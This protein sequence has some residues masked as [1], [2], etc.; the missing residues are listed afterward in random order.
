MG[1]Y[2]ELDTARRS[3]A[4]RLIGVWVL[5]ANALGAA[6]AGETFARA[7]E[8]ARRQLWPEARLAFAKGS[9]AYPRDKRFPIELAGV[10]WKLEDYGAAKRQLRRALSIDADDAFANE[11][12]ATIFLLEDNLEAS[13]RYW[14]RAGGPRLAE[15]QTQSNLRLQGALLERTFPFSAGTT[16][17]RRDYIAARA[18]L[19][20]LGIFPRYRIDLVP[21]EDADYA[22]RLRASEK[23]GFGA[24]TQDRLLNLFRGVFF[25]TLYPEYSNWRGRAINIDSLL[26]WDAQKQRVLFSVAGPMQGDPGR[27]GRVYVD[28]RRENW[29]LARTFR[30][31]AVP[32]EG[33]EFRYAA[34]GAE[35]RGLEPG[36]WSWRAAAE[37][38]W[39]DVPNRARYGIANQAVFTGG[40]AAAVQFGAGY[41][42]WRVPERRLTVTGESTAELGRVIGRELRPF[43]QLRTSVEANWLPRARGDDYAVNTRFYAGKVAGDAPL[44]RLFQLGIERDNDL[45]LRGHAGTAGGRKGNAP[46]GTGIVLANWEFDKI[47]YRNG[48]WS[49]SAGP[50]LDTGRAW[51]GG[52]GFGSQRWLT[53]AGVQCKLRVLGGAS[54]VVSWGKDLRT[55]GN[56][57][58][59]R[60]GR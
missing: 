57:V 19:D 16:L 34:G 26:R 17:Q 58:Y 28:F 46:L 39:R 15:V 33:L 5:F 29:D 52:R 18:R 41:S 20:Q 25:Q 9:A 50:L 30:R 8:L 11:F 51:D 6:D 55:G 40:A 13:L 54:V 12:L 24:T 48:F 56:V 3:A 47:V 7:M 22:L 36:G 42:L 4:R 53:D 49:V 23:N 38:S 44:D 10:Y 43:A 60:L 35:V 1:N 21:A 2:R 27:R 59:A 45:W 37:V 32:A 14:N 31:S